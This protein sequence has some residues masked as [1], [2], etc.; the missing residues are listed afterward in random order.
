MSADGIIM[1]A[2][3][4]QQDA[5][6]DG[7]AANPLNVRQVG[8]ADPGL[9]GLMGF[10]FA[11]FA[12]Q[13]E[14]LGV[15][16]EAP[17]FWIG[18]VFGGILQIIAGLLSYKQGDNF[19]FLVYSAFGWYW[20]LAPGF[21]VAHEIDFFDVSTVA[22]GLL[23]LLFALL[24]ACFVP[25]GAAYQSVLPVTLILV[26]LG[27]LFQGSS[28]ILESDGGIL[29]GT[30]ILLGA[31]TLAGYMLVAKFYKLTLGWNL[32]LGPAWLPGPSDR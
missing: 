23:V 17:V 20:I 31:A 1:A 9:I 3:T 4:A 27:L 8:L 32:P 29:V 11:T 28:E 13:L 19:H 18:A 14:H 25:A 7:S 24:A 6:P 30:W 5:R 10:T 15:Q 16:D 21:L 22:R 2:E 12:A 26:S